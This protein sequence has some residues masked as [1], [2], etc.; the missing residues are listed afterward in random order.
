M[1]I[2]KECFQSTVQAPEDSKLYNTVLR[3]IVRI[4]LNV[5]DVRWSLAIVHMGTGVVV[6]YDSSS[7]FL[8][9]SKGVAKSTISILE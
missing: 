6:M 5:R 7:N 8:Y 4:L 2:A 1:Y 9:E 3:T